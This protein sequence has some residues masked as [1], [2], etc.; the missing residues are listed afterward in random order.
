MEVYKT[1][2]ATVRV[3]GTANRDRLVEAT[4]RFLKHVEACRRREQKTKCKQ[5][6]KRNT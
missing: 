4:A 6:D 3:H 5:A 1:A 2:S